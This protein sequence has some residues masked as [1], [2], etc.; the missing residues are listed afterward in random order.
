MLPVLSQE[1]FYSVSNVTGLDSSGY[2]AGS[3][4]TAVGCRNG[5][6][7]MELLAKVNNGLDRIPARE[8]AI[9]DSTRVTCKGRIPGKFQRTSG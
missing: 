7:A 5:V 6:W 2:A 4:L 1:T 9:S 8:V 3:M